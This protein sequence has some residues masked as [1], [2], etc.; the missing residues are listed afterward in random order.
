MRFEYLE[1]GEKLE[2]T[3]KSHGAQQPEDN[4]VVAMRD[5]R[6]EH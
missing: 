1:L 4:A 2:F 6:V 3:C 5:V